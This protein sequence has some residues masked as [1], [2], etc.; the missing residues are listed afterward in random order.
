MARRRAK[1]DS[2]QGHEW[3]RH[4][5]CRIADR[6][7]SP[8]NDIRGAVMNFTVG[9]VLVGLLGAG[10]GLYLLWQFV[11]RFDSYMIRRRRA[12]I[13]KEAGGQ[14]ICRWGVDTEGNIGHV[15]CIRAPR[16][17]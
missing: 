14:S 4:H 11:E 5:F 10:V 13:D 7:D 6:L 17:D 1:N 16:Q 2:A 12:Q 15:R 9:S 8:R 3:L